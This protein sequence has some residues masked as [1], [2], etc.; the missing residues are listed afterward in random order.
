MKIWIYLVG[1]HINISLLLYNVLTE[2]WKAI[3]TLHFNILLDKRNGTR[4]VILMNEHKT[5]TKGAAQ[6]VLTER[7]KEVLDQYLELRFVK[8]TFQVNLWW[9]FN[10][11]KNNT[12]SVQLIS[13]V[14]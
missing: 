1:F 4:Y 12:F 6:L 3:L 13:L 11:K 10:C 7:S 14:N 9:L 5:M 8:K 2:S